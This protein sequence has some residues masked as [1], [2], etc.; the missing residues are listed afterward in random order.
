MQ[1]CLKLKDYQSNPL[2]MLNRTHIFLVYM[3]HL[4]KLLPRNLRAIQNLIVCHLPVKVLIDATRRPLASHTNTHT[5]SNHSPRE[6]MR[7]ML[8]LPLRHR[9]QP[10]L[11]Q[12]RRLARI[13]DDGRRPALLVLLACRALPGLVVLEY[14]VVRV[15]V[16]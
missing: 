16:A 12:R 1:E 13:R 14:V 8:V 10:Q 7:D 6:P 5:K 15:V 9:R 4:P 2:C 11:L 3:Q